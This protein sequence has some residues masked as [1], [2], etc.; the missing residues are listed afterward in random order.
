MKHLR[1]VTVA[2]A[3]FF[4]DFLNELYRAII[5]LNPGLAGRAY[6]DFVE[7]KKRQLSPL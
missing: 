7:E 1:P 6:Q 4:A 2:R 5:T 3:D